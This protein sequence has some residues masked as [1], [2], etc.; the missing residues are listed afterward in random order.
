MKM[1]IRIHYQL[2]W[3]LLVLVFAITVG[4]SE[5]SADGTSNDETSSYGIDVSFPIHKRIST[6]Y[7]WLPHNVDPDNNP[8]PKQYED[9]PLQPLGD[10]QTLYNKHL[11]GCRSFYGKDARQCDVYEY[12]RMLMNIRQPQSM[13][14]Y[15]DVGFLKTRAPQEIIDLMTKF[16][17]QN[18]L[19]QEQEN[20]PVGVSDL[21]YTL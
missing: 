5:S 18:H 3:I 4:R 14:N 15:T 2:R 9:M 17:E 20:W 19:N 16:W 7:P 10:R 21:K 1:K 13:Q 6:N 8:T 12:D 11:S